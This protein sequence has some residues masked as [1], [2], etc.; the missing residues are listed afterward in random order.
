[1]AIILVAHYVFLLNQRLYPVL[2]H[3]DLRSEQVHVLDHVLYQVLVGLGFPRF[4]YPHDHGIYDVLSLR[5]DLLLGGGN[6][7]NV[8]ARRPWDTICCLLNLQPTGRGEDDT[9][10]RV[11]EGSRDLHLLFWGELGLA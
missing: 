1:M 8:L 4:H 2:Y 7:P 6:P 10:A 3:A 11:L 5:S 9:V